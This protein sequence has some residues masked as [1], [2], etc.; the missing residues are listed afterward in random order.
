V[1]AGPQTA[2]GKAVVRVCGIEILCE[3]ALGDVGNEADVSVG[4]AE[5]G[6]AVEQAE[7]A[8]VPSTAKQGGEMSLGA[9]DGVEDGGEF[10]G[11]R[12]QAAVGG[13]LL[14]AQS[15]NQAGGA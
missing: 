5:W 14:I 9:L 8:V 4:C 1:D 12:K 7:V 6:G 3:F 11:D 2:I 13:W 10:F 15:V